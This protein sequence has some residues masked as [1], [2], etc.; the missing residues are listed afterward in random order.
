MTKS[1]AFVNAAEEKSPRWQDIGRRKRRKSRPRK[2]AGGAVSTANIVA[3]DNDG[4]FFGETLRV[5]RLRVGENDERRAR[6]TSKERTPGEREK[7][8]GPHG[9]V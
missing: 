9:N 3:S 6:Y 8:F 2:P 5:D 1:I 7:M 4:L